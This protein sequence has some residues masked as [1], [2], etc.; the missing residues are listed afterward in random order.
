M[1]A[2]PTVIALFALICATWF[3]AS[4]WTVPDETLHYSVRFKWGLI[5]A[6]VGVAKLQTYNIPSTGR[7]IATLSGKSVDLLGHYYAANDTIVGSVMSD[8][9]QIH[10]TQQ[11]DRE[12]GE[13]AIETVTGTATAQKNIGPEIEQLPGG[14]YLHSRVSNYGSGLTI[15]LLSVFYYMRQI[16][17]SQY[18]DG[19]AFHIDITNGTEV[20]ALDIN[21]TGKEDLGELGDAYHISLTFT[22]QQTGKSDSLE[23]WI[24]TGNDRTPLIINGSLSV[25]HIECHFLDADP[26]STS[27]ESGC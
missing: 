26:L 6:N 10:S 3:T 25:G 16:D 20:E 22:A 14:K 5:D 18:S 2:R 17:Y 11:I 1:R 21:Y 7:F 13:F 15:D 8:A 19:Q 27:P 4:A 9:V 23:V 24:S 12:H